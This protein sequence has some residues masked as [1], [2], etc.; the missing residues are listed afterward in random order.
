MKKI[1]FF[2]AFV[3]LLFSLIPGL[4]FAQN[5]DRVLIYSASGEI[6][7]MRAEHIDS[8]KFLTEPVDMTLN[9][10]IV[11]HED[12]ETGKM[13]V[14]IGTGGADVSYIK[15]VIPETYMIEN[16]NDYQLLTMFDVEK[17]KQRNLDV[18]TVALEQ[19]YDLSGLQRGYSYT[20]LF[21]AYDQYGCPDNVHK[22]EFTVPNGPL[23]GNP[24]VNVKIEEVKYNGF[25]VYFEPNDDV[26]GY[27][28]LA[29]LTDN[30]SREQ[31]MKMFGIPDLKHYVIQLGTDFATRKAHTGAKDF[32][33]KDFSPNTEYSVFVVLVDA[34]G[35]YSDVLE[36]KQTTAK[37]G[38]A[39]TAHVTIEVSDITSTSA[40]VTNTPD[41]N[42][43]SYRE[44]VFKKDEGNLPEI[45]KMLKEEP[46]SME[47]PF[48]MEAFTQIWQD[49][50][51]GATYVAVAIARN[52]NN[53]WGPTATKEF[54]LPE[55]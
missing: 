18:Y 34:N 43:S 38:T 5:D 31:M 42:T 15:L 19:E 54:T 40:A 23:A 45:E 21:L 37:K 17:A 49:L 39:E 44:V 13:K 36:Y 10:T 12:G 35:Q 1:Y 8:I 32:S 41:E 6:I 26:K 22:V 28:F 16:M 14:K 48:R 24:V 7:G 9:P 4:T 20:A 52:A 29:D 25:K 46:E 11:P 2:P 27:F 33:Y 50:V 55:K 53:E 3:A 51:P 47:L 30:P